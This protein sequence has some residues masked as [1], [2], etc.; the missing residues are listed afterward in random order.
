MS[1]DVAGK[2]C[3]GHSPAAHLKLAVNVGN[4]HWSVSCFQ[5]RPDL[6]LHARPRRLGTVRRARC[7][8]Q[9]GLGYGGRPVR[10]AESL[11]REETILHQCLLAEERRDLIVQVLPLNLTLLDPRVDLLERF[12]SSDHAARVARL[13]TLSS[14]CRLPDK[15]FSNML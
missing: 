1:R 11:E 10:G 14:T 12:L 6:P 15:K 8:G 2:A 3:T 7:G 5:D 9:P 13:E 4:V